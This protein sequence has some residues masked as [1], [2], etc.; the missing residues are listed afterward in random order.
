MKKTFLTIGFCIAA[1][2][3]FAQGF[4]SFKV[5]GAY[6]G[7]LLK[8]NTNVN[9]VIETVVGTDIDIKNVPVKYKLLSNCEFAPSTPYSAD[10]TKPQTVTINKK[11][12][13]QKDWNL[14]VHQLQP[15]ALPL[16]LQ[17]GKNNLCDLNVSNP[18]PWAGYGI[19]YSKPTVVRFG[20]FGVGF[21]VAYAAEAKQVSFTLNVV[22]KENAAF[23]G[24]F[25][26]ETSI[27]GRSWKLLKTY[28]ADKPFT[29]HAEET[30]D[31]PTEARFVRWIY[32]VREKQNV[33]LNNITIK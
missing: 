11:D 17:F 9:S 23:A 3:A 33:N 29:N 24:E 18:K 10:F 21:M 12:G 2:G 7:T 13:T 31:L 28:S 26:V 15:A 32:A 6:T 14:I 25:D 19:D 8:H 5:E 30:L 22:S 4:A 16:H 27:D 20:N 1:L